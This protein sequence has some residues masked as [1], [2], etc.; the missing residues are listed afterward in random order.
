MKNLYNLPLNRAIPLISHGIR[1]ILRLPQNINVYPYEY[2]EKDFKAIIWRSIDW[3]L[4]N[5]SHKWVNPPKNWKNMLKTKSAQLA[6]DKFYR[7][8]YK[9]PDADYLGFKKVRNFINYWN[10]LLVEADDFGNR[11]KFEQGKNWI[12]FTY[13]MRTT[14]APG[15]NRTNKNW[16]RAQNWAER[17][18]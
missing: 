3:L 12:D 10:W 6:I 13:L 9:N 18:K 11:W 1:L 5:K 4:Y 14:I 7:N 8:V 16:E 17:R 2:A 15:G